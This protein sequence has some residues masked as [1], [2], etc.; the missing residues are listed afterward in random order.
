MR[1]MRLHQLLAYQRDLR[2][3]PGVSQVDIYFVGRL[4]QRAEE[5]QPGY[6]A[7]E[8]VDWVAEARPQVIQS[9][10]NLR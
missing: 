10:G 8:K 6:S 1:G 7:F 9:P 5:K 2:G 3:S 4:I